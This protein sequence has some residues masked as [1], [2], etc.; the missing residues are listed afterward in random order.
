MRTFADKSKKSFPLRP[1]DLRTIIYL[2]RN[3]NKAER[4]LREVYAFPFNKSFW[5]KD[6]FIIM[7]QELKIKI[8]LLYPFIIID[9]PFFFL[10]TIIIIILF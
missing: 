1:L 10:V 2:Q 3:S 6:A 5:I 7:I 9:K 4:K 8:L